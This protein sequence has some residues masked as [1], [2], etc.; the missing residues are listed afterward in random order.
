MARTRASTSARK[1][2]APQTAT[3]AP[4]GEVLWIESKAEERAVVEEKNWPETMRGASFLIP[5]LVLE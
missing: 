1:K 4:V 3:E 5:S 2:A